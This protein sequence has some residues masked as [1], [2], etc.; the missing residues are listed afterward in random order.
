MFGRKGAARVLPKLPSRREL[1]HDIEEVFTPLHGFKSRPRED[2]EVLEPLSPDSP[3]AAV[4]ATSAKAQS[5]FATQLS[6]HVFCRYA[7]SVGRPRFWAPRSTVKCNLK[8]V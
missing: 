5:P 1:E 3:P 6:D 2:P 7:T 8:S 4:H